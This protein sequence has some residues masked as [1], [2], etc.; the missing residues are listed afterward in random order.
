MF[1]E[2]AISVSTPTRNFAVFF[3]VVYLIVLGSIQLSGLATV[4]LGLLG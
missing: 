2:R 3:P 1:V 4:Y